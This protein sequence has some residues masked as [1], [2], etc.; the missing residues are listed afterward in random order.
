M[1]VNRT[2]MS[3]KADEPRTFLLSR[4]TFV[5]CFI[6]A[7]GLFIGGFFTPPQGVID[8]SILK[9]IGELLGFPLLLYA[10]RAI[11]LGLKVKLVA[12]NTSIEIS[13]KEEEREEDSQ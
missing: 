4:I 10:Y 9:G 13:K 5:I 8:G 6:T 11:E 12:G 2:L 1:N 3:E 7:V